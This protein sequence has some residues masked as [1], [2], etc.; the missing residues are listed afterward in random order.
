MKQE[1]KNKIQ[2]G[3]ATGIG[4]AIGTT[5]GMVAGSVIAKEMDVPEVIPDPDELGLQEEQEVTGPVEQNE[6]ELV[7]VQE[8]DPSKPVSEGETFNDESSVA[9][10]LV[11]LEY[12]TVTSEDGSQVDLA[13]V[14]MDGQNVVIADVDMDGAADMV[15]SD[16]NGDGMLSNDEFMDVSG[17]G[18][19]MA[20][21]QDYTLMENHTLMA[22]NEDYIN[23]ADIDE[24]MA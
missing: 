9:P 11:V 12:E 1:T 24:Y 3:V 6:T 23:N 4:S 21:F 18:L 20:T 22:Q 15:A 10:E 8:A 13:L 7:V 2:S 14:S 5:V 17:Q 16:L 19:A